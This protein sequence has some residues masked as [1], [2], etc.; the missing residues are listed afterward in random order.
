[1]V[2]SGLL[3][4]DEVALPV[5]VRIELLSGAS[6]VDRERLRRSLS[7]LPVL[8]PTDATWRLMDTWI[9][10]AGA[11]HERFGVAD[12]LIGALSSEAGALLWSLDSDFERLHRLEFVD[13]YDPPDAESGGRR[14]DAA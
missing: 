13:T 4:A 1:M 9:D 5:P 3:D 8:Y 10:R 14:P 11:R 12:L 2:L 6:R 7:A